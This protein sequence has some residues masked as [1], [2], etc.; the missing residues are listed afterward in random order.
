ML[1]KEAQKLKVRLSVA[2]RHRNLKLMFKSFGALKRMGKV[3]L[4]NSK[5]TSSFDN[6]KSSRITSSFDNR[7]RSTDQKKSFKSL[8]QSKKS[9]TIARN[10]S[11]DNI[12]SSKRSK[13]SNLKRNSS[14]KT[15]SSGKQKLSRKS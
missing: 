7:S 14:L 4:K 1:N 8:T 11:A 10:S 9:V 6:R 2:T 15:Q 12:K 5:I 13:S 3:L